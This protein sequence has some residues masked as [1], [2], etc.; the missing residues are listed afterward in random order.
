M[1]ISD[2]Y[3]KNKLLFLAVFFAAFSEYKNVYGYSEAQKKQ[4]QT[5]REVI[6]QVCRSSMPVLVVDN[7]LK[8][9][10]VEKYIDVD[11]DFIPDVAHGEIVESVLKMSGRPTLRY[12]LEGPSSIQELLEVFTK[13]LEEVKSGQ[14]KISAINFS[15][16]NPL[17]IGALADEM[18]SGTTRDNIFDNKNQIMKAMIEGFK[19]ADI[20]LYE[21]L[22]DIFAEFEILKIPVFVA[23]GN[24]GE[25]YVNFFSL[26]PSVI[27]VGSL[28]LQGGPVLTS[29]NSSLVTVWRQGEHVVK[30]QLDGSV[31][32][33][34][35]GVPELSSNLLSRQ[36]PFVQRFR[37]R[38]A[39]DVLRATPTDPESNIYSRSTPGGLEVLM[40]QLKS[41]ALY[42]INDLNHYF[43]MANTAYG[44]ASVIRGKYFDRA[45]S[46][47]MD[48]DAQN[49][50]IFDPLGSGDQNQVLLLS[51]TSYAAPNIC[52]K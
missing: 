27:S 13:I 35:D 5:D 45:Q 44:K 47:G 25:D 1:R 7:F 51:G 50:L 8:E 21:E 15:Q 41:D 48:V 30:R 43:R 14:L 19:S 37:G 22:N 36:E 9:N 34:N 32:F 42:E 31:D 38:L 3:I 16:V 18:A 4:V 28:A 46:I 29:G 12:N 2:S 26:L 49:R 10:V 11:G 52:Q 33:N 20:S 24:Q 23:A 17:R 39:N 6:G 40:N